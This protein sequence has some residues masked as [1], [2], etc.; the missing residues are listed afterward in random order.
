MLESTTDE[1]AN[2]RVPNWL[3]QRSRWSK[4]YM[5][6]LLVHTRRPLA[7][8]RE[9]GTRA[10]AAFLLTVGGAVVTAL[11]APVFWLL[12][13]L[14]I[15]FEPAWIPALFPGPVYYAASVSLVLGNFALVFLSVVA[16]VRRGHDDLA[17]HALLIP[18]YLVLMSVATYVALV[19]LVVRP[20]H[21]HK[22][23]HALHL[24]GQPT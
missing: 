11:L 13:I 22:T 4:G 7:L 12:L 17:P 15:G 1:E 3:R 8:R 14:W 21:W 18:F 5:Q 19:E 20:H 6:T 24:A 16:A 2:S 23:E 9:L 10:S